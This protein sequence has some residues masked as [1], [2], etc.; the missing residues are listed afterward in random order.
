MR[1]VRAA[2]VR[3]RDR[4]LVIA[5][6][7][8]RL[9][10]RPTVSAHRVVAAAR[11]TMQRSSSCIV[12]TSDPR[13][14]PSAVSARVLQPDRPDADLVVHL[15]TAPWSRKALQMRAT[16]EVVLAY[17]DSRRRAGVTAYCSAEFCTDPAVRARVFRP[18]WRAF[19][20]DGPGSPD[21]AVIRCRPHAVEVWDASRGVSPDPFGLACSRVERRG[22]DWILVPLTG[23]TAAPSDR[24]V[25]R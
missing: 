17:S 7:R 4:L 14:T 24:D 2:A 5:A 20:P 22:A 9:R 18:T 25:D 11:A 12:I 13:A 19:W 3:V 10:A 8:L 16:S 15:G 6:R 1:R 21:Y 23:G